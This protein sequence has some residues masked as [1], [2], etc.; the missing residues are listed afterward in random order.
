MQEPLLNPETKEEGVKRSPVTVILAVA[1]VVAIVTSVWFLL[2]SPLTSNPAPVQ[3]TVVLTMDSVER[4]YAKNLSVENIALS[5]AEN[6]IHQEV[7]TLS[8]EVLNGGAQ[9]VL[10]LDLTVEFSDDL[11][12]VVLRETRGVLGT[13]HQALAAGERRSFEISFDHVPNSWNMQKPVVRI[14][15]L[16]VAPRK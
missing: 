2:K 16:Q 8:G 12:Q 9:A 5:R 6:F 7:T 15:Y 4:D 11:N 1:V 14:A 3:T 13:P 10:A